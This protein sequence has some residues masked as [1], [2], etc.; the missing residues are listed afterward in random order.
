MLSLAQNVR[1]RGHDCQINE[2]MGASH[3]EQ[4]KIQSVPI[5]IFVPWAC[6]FPV[7]PEEHFHLTQTKEPHDA[8]FI[9]DQL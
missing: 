3:S 7:A 4:R 8:V 5:S 2:T 1:K 6:F 9:E